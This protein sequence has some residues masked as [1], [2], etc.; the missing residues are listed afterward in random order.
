MCVFSASAA[1]ADDD[2]ASKKRKALWYL[3]ILHSHRFGST[4][5]SNF[6]VCLIGLKNYNFRFFFDN[7]N[8]FD[9]FFVHWNFLKTRLKGNNNLQQQHY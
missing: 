1:A 6:P 8:F 7:L 4:R 3:K 9:I 2:Y 5:F